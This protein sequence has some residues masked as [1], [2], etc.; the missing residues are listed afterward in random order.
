MRQLVNAIA[1]LCGFA[2]HLKPRR[3]WGLADW[4]A[5]DA[6]L[7]RAGREGDDALVAREIARN[8]P[9]AAELERLRARRTP[10][11]QW[12]EASCDLVDPEAIIRDDS[13]AEHVRA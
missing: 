3:W 8:Q 12:S 10:I 7:D 13:S 1:W 4:R 6:R 2:A 5:Y 11:E 9:T